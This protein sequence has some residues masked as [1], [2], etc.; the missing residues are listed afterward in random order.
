MQELHTMMI[1]IDNADSDLEIAIGKLMKEESSGALRAAKS[2]ILK[3]KYDIA[4]RIVGC[5][6]Q[7]VRALGERYVDS[8]RTGGINN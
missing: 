3:N 2:M 4:A 7:E 8:N 6:E 5:S 1:Y